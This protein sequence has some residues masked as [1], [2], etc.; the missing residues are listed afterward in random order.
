MANE[1]IHFDIQNSGVQIAPNAQYTVQNF[2]GSEYAHSAPEG[3]MYGEEPIPDGTVVDMYY[4]S[5]TKPDP[6]ENEII[7]KSELKLCEQRLEDNKVLCLYGEDGIGVTTLLSQFAKKHSTH[8]VSYFYDGQSIMWLTPEVMEHNIIKQL[9]WYAFGAEDDFNIACAQNHTLITL[10]N[11]VCLKSRKEKD[12]LYFIFDGFDN[13]PAEKKESVKRFLAYMDWSSWRFIFSGRKEQ[14]ADLLPQSKKLSVSE[15]E[16]I[17]FGDADVKDYFRKTANDITDETLNFLCDITRGKGHRMEIV[18]HRYIEKGRLQD[19][20]QSDVTGE[21]DLYDEDFSDLFES[22][23]EQALDFFTTLSFVD[24]HITTSLMAAIMSIPI[25]ELTN[26]VEKYDDFVKFK[27]GELVV[28]RIQG[29]HKYLKKR[30]KQYKQGT[31]L[32]ILKELQ[33]SCNER[34][35][36]YA[37]PALMKSAGKTESLV[38]Y[39]NNENIQQ[40][41]MDGKSQAALNEQCEYGYDACMSD[42]EKYAASLFRFAINRS[43]SREIEKNELWDN[44]IEAL[45]ATGHVSQALALAQNVYLSEER[46]KAYLLIARK[47]ELLTTSDYDYDFLKENI[48]RLVSEINFEKMPD[49]AIELAKL[50]MFVDYKAAVGIVDRV[51]QANKEIFNADKAYTIMSLMSDKT[52]TEMGNVTNFDLADSRI[53]NEDLRTFAHAAKH[54]FADVSVDYFLAELDKLSSDSRKLHL[55]QIWLPEHET[56]DDIGK[57]ILKAIQLI[58]AVSN[59]DMPKAKILNSVC[60]SMS[61]MTPDDMSKAMAYIESM[62]ETIKYPTLDYVDA[63]LTIIEATKDVL[64]EKSRSHLED[65][66][67]HIQDQTDESLKVACLSKLLGRFDYLG[68]KAETEKTLGCSSVEIRKEITD[69]VHKLFLETAYHLKV[70]E[71]PI[72]A[73]VSEYT[74]MIDELVAGMNTESRKKRAYSLAATYYLLKQKEE[75]IEP[76]RFF[77]LIANTDNTYDNRENPLDMLSQMLLHADEVRHEVFLPVIIKNFDY[78]VELERTPRKVFILMRLYLWMNKHFTG[79]NFINKIK[80]EIIKSWKSIEPLKPKIEC[81]YFLAKNFAK[82]SIEDAENFLDECNKLKSGCL[83]SSSSCES[84][85]D[86]AMNLYVRSMCLLVR[87]GLCGDETFLSQFKDDTDNQLSSVEQ[88]L[89]WSNIALEYYLANDHEQFKSLCSEYIPADFEKFS[90]I[91]QKYIIYGMAPAMFLNNQDAFY[92]RLDCYDET[93]RNDCLQHV[94]EFVIC[95]QAS[96]SDAPMEP[97]AYNLDYYDYENLISILGHATDDDIFYKVTDVISKSL[98][99]GKPRKTLSNEQKKSVVNRVVQIIDTKLP[100]HRGI[101]HDGYKLACLAAM[102]HVNGDFGNNRKAYW[103]NEIE[104]ITNDADK[105]FLYLQLAPYFSKRS[106][107]EYFFKKG[108]DG[109]NSLSSTFDK[110]SRLDMSIDMCTENNLGDM[111]RPVAE[112]AMKSLRNNGTLDDHK[113]LIDLV[114]QQKPEL[115]EEMVNDLDNDPARIQYKQRLLRHISSEKKLRQAHEELDNLESLSSREQVSFFSKRLDDIVKG[116]GQLLDIKTIFKLSI[117]HIHK[118]SIS[119]TQYA[120]LYIMEDLFCKYK[121]SKENKELLLAMHSAL[122]YNLKLV[123]SLAAGTK[124]R[125]DRIDSMIQD[126]VITDDSYIRIGEESKAMGYILKWYQSLKYNVLTIIDPYFKPNNL[127]VVKTLCDINND[128]EIRILMHRRNTSNEDYLSYWHSISSGVTNKI[129][130]NFVWFED[131]PEDGPLHDRFWICSDEENDKDNGIILSS[132]DTLGKKETAITKAEQ[133]AISEVLNSY[134]RYVYT[135]IKKS[136]GRVL[137]YDSMELK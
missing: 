131:K 38:A 74:T 87:Y 22:G 125:I 15:Y 78:F 33:K 104:K 120:I 71:E 90:L 72:K 26:L 103:E 14:I 29:F 61:K 6:V 126:P 24:F 51:A 9:Y 109:A 2:Y 121:Q 55:L 65:L 123:L 102:E 105:A 76:E 98:R 7:R 34:K 27:Q 91:N 130:L 64:P 70:V 44:E 136:S 77:N 4:F 48:D 89:I 115:A 54:L 110:V 137:K 85:Y 84:A 106:D 63:E 37:I 52:D 113:K 79:E 134:T 8:C 119:K 42:M 35:Y 60:Q 53:K 66:Y 56:K 86:I 68:K 135:R 88:A 21:S 1:Q 80:H 30:L 132:I 81:G 124:E 10:W 94:A 73:L 11:R 58:I 59:T 92:A 40:I 25:D 107:K 45:L 20:L 12:P 114:Y 75:K 16:I 118:Y 101:Q 39:L 46:L 36:N 57:A 32:K 28:F 13:I 97:K 128:L 96:L 99:D 18:L 41:F 82:T 47:K 50:L 129:Q 117:T 49:K 69:T 112:S 31:E 67:L 93:F 127:D 62:N 111:V 23:D 17:A 19:L 43:M 3:I 122:R 133:G 83:L 100:T 108:I 116:T 95:K 5:V